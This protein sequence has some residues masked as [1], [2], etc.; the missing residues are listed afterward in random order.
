[1]QFFFYSGEGCRLGT[2]QP[3]H[4]DAAFVAVVDCCVGA[5]RPAALMPH[6]AAKAAFQDSELVRRLASGGPAERQPAVI[7][8]LN[9]GIPSADGM[10]WKVAASAQGLHVVDGECQ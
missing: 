10:Q 5:H 1:M 3:A 2:P 4:L 8:T 9:R 6:H 7:P